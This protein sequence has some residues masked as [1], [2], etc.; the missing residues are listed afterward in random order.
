MK[1]QYYRQL[2]GVSHTEE[3]VRAIAA[4]NDGY[5]TAPNEEGEV[6]TRAGNMN[7]LFKAPYAN[8]KEARYAA[9]CSQFVPLCVCLC[10]G[11][12]CFVFLFVF[13]ML[14]F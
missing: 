10:C 7:D 11:R 1:G 3:E 6:T 8:E 5:L 9:R 2:I 13:R 4:D 14:V 12:V